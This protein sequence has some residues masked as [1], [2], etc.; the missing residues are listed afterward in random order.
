MAG[1]LGWHP[2]QKESLPWG[3]PTLVMSRPQWSANSWIKLQFRRVL[4]PPATGLQQGDGPSKTSF[5]DPRVVPTQTTETRREKGGGRDSWSH[6]SCSWSNPRWGG[7]LALPL[8]RT[9][10][11]PHS[12]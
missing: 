10:L 3:G 5:G 8:P 1:G 7:T 9:S 12:T 6:L 4:E 11:Q 2:G